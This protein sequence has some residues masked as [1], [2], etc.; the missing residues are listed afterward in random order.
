MIVIA[1]VLDYL[2]L[3]PLLVVGLVMGVRKLREA[4]REDGGETG[5]AEGDGAP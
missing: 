1:H 2:A 5:A 4:R 3:A